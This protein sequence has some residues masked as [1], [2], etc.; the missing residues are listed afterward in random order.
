[1]CAGGR[2]GGQM[3][4]VQLEMNH[5]CKEEVQVKVGNEST[6][7]IEL[8]R[9]LEEREEGESVRSKREKENKK[10]RKRVKGEEKMIAKRSVMHLYA[11]REDSGHV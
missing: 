1:M 5:G 2:G 7:G 8:A 6:G 4:Y 9:D 11:I 10:G 3:K